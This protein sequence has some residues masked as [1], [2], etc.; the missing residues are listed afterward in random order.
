MIKPALPKGTRD[1]PPAVLRKRQFILDT[2][3]RVFERFGF[4]PLETPS[5]ENLDTL[6]GKYGEEG[7]KLMF[8]ILDNGEILDKARQARD[9]SELGRL[10]CE[11]ALRYDLTIPFA[12]FVVMNQHEL[13][14]PFRRYQIQPVWRADRPQKSRYREFYQC[15]ADIIGTDSLIC[16]IELLL[17][18]QTVFTQLGLQGFSL[19]I[20]HRKILEGLAA[21]VGRPEMLSDITMVLDKLDKIGWEGVSGELQTKGLEEK[22]LG[23]IDQFIHMKG[24]NSQILEQLT[25]LFP[26]GS[27]GNQGVTDLSAILQN[28]YTSFPDHLSIDLSLARGLSYYTGTILEARAPQHLKIGSIGGGGRYDNLTGLFGLS[29][30]SGVGISFGVDRIYDVMEELQLFAGQSGSAT[31]VIFLNMGEPYAARAFALMQQLRER[32]IAAEI[33][34]SPA[35]LDKQIKYAG[36]RGITFAAII[37]SSELESG[38]ISLKNLGTGAQEQISEA[39]LLACSF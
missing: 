10:I 9:S 5:M 28:P 27:S 37:G 7:D 23:L 17:L 29:G 36:K 15:D 6:A 4:Q 18:Y 32:G 34:P 33:Y 13:S 25:L 8:R 12:R 38:N 3:R 30:I 19:R 21:L 31:R 35:K 26:E 11:K 22:A 39:A 24:S 1:F 2:I 14:F 20:N 16:E